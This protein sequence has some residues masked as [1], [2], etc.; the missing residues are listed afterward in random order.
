MVTTM[1]AFGGIPVPGSG[2]KVI[3]TPW[4]ATMAT[5]T[6]F[7]AMAVNHKADDSP[8]PAIDGNEVRLGVDDDFQVRLDAS[9][10]NLD[11]DRFPP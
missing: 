3:S 8:S 11:A 2:V 7:A 9:G 1:V 6:G 4:E 5:P 10:R